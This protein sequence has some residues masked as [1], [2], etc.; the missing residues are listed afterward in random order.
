MPRLS[1][2]HFGFHRL[3]TSIGL[4]TATWV[5]HFIVVSMH[6]WIQGLFPKGLSK[7]W[8]LEFYGYVTKAKAQRFVCI[9]LT[10][11]FWYCRN[12]GR[13]GKNYV[14][15][16]F[17]HFC[18]FA[19]S[20]YGT[21]APSAA[22]AAAATQGAATQGTATATKRASQNARPTAAE[23]EQNKMETKTIGK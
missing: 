13:K 7:D 23:K 10:F 5:Y 21:S 17:D 20:F 4:L 15:A 2:K 22:T 3:T 9:K 8:L 18:Q 16:P 11:T 6:H 12:G 19:L 1:Q 14:N